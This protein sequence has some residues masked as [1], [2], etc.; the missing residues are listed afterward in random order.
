MYPYQQIPM[1]KPGAGKDT[2]ALI[3]G[4][5]SLFGCS[6]L[7]PISLVFGILAPIFAIRYSRMTGKWNAASGVGLAFGI[8]GALFSLF[9]CG[10]LVYVIVTKDPNSIYGY[11][12]SLTEIQPNM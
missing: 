9:L 6:C 4:L 1:P 8:L 3:F 5:I 2:L 7:G 12:K 10:L 11:F